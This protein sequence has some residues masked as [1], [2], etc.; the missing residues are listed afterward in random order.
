MFYWVYQE[1]EII[2]DCLQSKINM[3]VFKVIYI[4]IWMVE[5]GYVE[6]NVFVSLVYVKVFFDEMDNVEV[7]FFDVDYEV[8]LKENV[9]QYKNE[10]EMCILEYVVFEVKLMVEDFVV[11]CNCLVELLFEFEIIKDDI[12]FMECNYGVLLSIFL[13]ED[14]FSVVIKDMV[15]NMLEGSV[16]GFYIDQGKYWAVKLVECCMI[17]DFVDI[18]YILIQVQVFEQFVLVEKIIDSL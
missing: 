14:V 4:L 7:M 16:Y 11:L 13:I 12:V 8:Y 1:N 15:M 10:E 9:E 5:M 3:L 17:V 6:Q 18:C 2:K